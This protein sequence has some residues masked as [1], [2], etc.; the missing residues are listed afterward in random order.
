MITTLVD[1]AIYGLLIGAFVSVV[2]SMFLDLCKAL[3]G[4]LP[5]HQRAVDWWNVLTL[6]AQLAVVVI[7]VRCLVGIFSGN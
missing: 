7:V 1:I 3:G 6:L 2:A 4:L 5:S